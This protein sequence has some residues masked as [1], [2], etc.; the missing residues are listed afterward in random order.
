MGVAQ[1]ELDRVSRLTAMGEFASALAHE[2]LQPITA[3]GLNAKAALD[4]LR[5]PVP[6]LEEVRASLRNVVEAGQRAA[7]VT[8]RNRELYRYR[9]VRTAPVDMNRVIEET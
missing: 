2:I 6:H 3:I 8:L 1:A 4:L 5:H 9:T 7:D